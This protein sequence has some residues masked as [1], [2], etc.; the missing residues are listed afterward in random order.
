M[1]EDFVFGQGDDFKPIELDTLLED[2]FGTA[3]PSA[4]ELRAARQQIAPLPEPAP[5]IPTQLQAA[6]EQYRQASQAEYLQVHQATWLQMVSAVF[7]ACVAGAL[8]LLY[9]ISSG[10]GHRFF[11]AACLCPVSI[12]PALWLFTRA[13]ALPPAESYVFAPT[14]A[15]YYAAADGV[16]IRCRRREKY[17]ANGIRFLFGTLALCLGFIA[18]GFALGL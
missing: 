18:A 9:T 10:D 16:L 17:L 15:N 2:G 7:M 5:E 3:P 8:C 11:L 12:L 13:A 6:Q 14:A 1:R 4:E